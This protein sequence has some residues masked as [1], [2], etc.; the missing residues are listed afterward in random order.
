MSVS[1]SHESKNSV[2]AVLESKDTGKTFGDLDYALS[3]GA[4]TFGVPGA[5]V[6]E[7]SKNEVSLTFESQ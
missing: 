7:E 5:A 2:A 1:I 6:I 3:E 4:G